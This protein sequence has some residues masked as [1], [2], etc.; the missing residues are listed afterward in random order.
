MLN[1]VKISSI[2]A[3]IKKITK[4][5]D[6]YV[7]GSFANGNQNEHSDLDVAVIKDDISN[8]EAETFEIRKK[9]I[10]TG[11]VPLDLVFLDRT[12]FQKRKHKL[13]SLYYEIE[14]KGIKLSA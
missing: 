8:E 3:L 4:T 6:V 11:Y 14:K 12:Q 9:M 13:G 2:L 7:F 10:E 1:Q 5:E